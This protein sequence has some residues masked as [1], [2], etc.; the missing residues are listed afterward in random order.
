MEISF[1][2]NCITEEHYTRNF[3]KKLLNNKTNE[4]KQSDYNTK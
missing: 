2:E 3:P 4:I 1:V